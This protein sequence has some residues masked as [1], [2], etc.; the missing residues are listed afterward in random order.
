MSDPRHAHIDR[1][2][3]RIYT[4]DGVEVPSVTSQLKV[5]A[6]G[7]L[8]NWLIRRAV[9]TSLRMATRSMREVH[10][11]SEPNANGERHYSGAVGEIVKELDKPSKAATQGVGVHEA[12]ESWFATGRIPEIPENEA[13]FVEQAIAWAM[14]WNPRPLY[15]EPEVYAEAGYAGSVDGIFE[16]NGLTCI[17]DYK[18]GGIYESAAMQLAA[19]AHADRLY[20]RTSEE[21]CP[22][23]SGG[24]CKCEWIAMPAVDRLAVLA[25]KPDKYE[26][27]WVTPMAAGLAWRAFQGAQAIQAVKRHKTLFAPARQPEKVEAA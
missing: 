10:K 21:P 24:E 16:I 26:L 19:Y 3:R 20:P 18:T 14:E 23:S 9:D 6:S 7:G 22:I 12:L 4:F 25:L 27:M 17:V 15:Q 11:Q 2:K 13:P 8:Q 5:M 1:W